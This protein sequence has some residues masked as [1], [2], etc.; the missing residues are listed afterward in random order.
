[1]KKFLL[2]RFILIVLAITMFPMTTTYISIPTVECSWWGKMIHGE[3]NK[4]KE[5]EIRR[6]QQQQRWYYEQQRRRQQEQRRK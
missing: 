1:M 5:A 4:G 2:T 3:Y 6:R